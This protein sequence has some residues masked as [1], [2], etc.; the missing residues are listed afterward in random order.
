MALGAQ[1]DFTIQ[2]KKTH[3]KVILGYQRATFSANIT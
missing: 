2:K 1:R 3:N